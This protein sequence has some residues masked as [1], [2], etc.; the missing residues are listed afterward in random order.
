[1]SEGLCR[2]A[3][4]TD[5][6][7]RCTLYQTPQDY[8]HVLLNFVLFLFGPDEY[9]QN[10]YFIVDTDDRGAGGRNHLQNYGLN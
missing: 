7:G 3:Q 8:G 9:A 1:M 5:D 6:T 4:L 10:A 2:G